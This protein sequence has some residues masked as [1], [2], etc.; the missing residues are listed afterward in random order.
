M[1][2]IKQSDY[3]FLRSK[4][5]ANYVREITVKVVIHSLLNGDISGILGAGAYIQPMSIVTISVSFN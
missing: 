4:K 5:N 1:I 3:S 2:R